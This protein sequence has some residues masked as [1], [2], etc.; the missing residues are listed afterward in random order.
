[1]TVRYKKSKCRIFPF[2]YT[3]TILNYITVIEPEVFEDM[4]THELS[5]K[6]RAIMQEDAD[7][8]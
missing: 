1:M 3:K 4:S 5:D 6:V 7:K 2:A 8:Y